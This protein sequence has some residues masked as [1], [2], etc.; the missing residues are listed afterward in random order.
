MCSLFSGR[1]IRLCDLLAIKLKKLKMNW[2]LKRIFLHLFFDKSSLWPQESAR[3]SLGLLPLTKGLN[4]KS[5]AIYLTFTYCKKRRDDNSNY[6]QNKIEKYGKLSK[7]ENKRKYNK[8]FV[9][10]LEHDSL[11]FFYYCCKSREIFR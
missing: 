3:Y 4:T 5:L 10:I 6:N 7:D 8:C 11:C 1:K 9:N 2:L